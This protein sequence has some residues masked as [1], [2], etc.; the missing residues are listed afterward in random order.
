MKKQIKIVFMLTASILSVFCN[1]A[2]ACRIRFPPLIDIP[3]NMIVFTG[4]YIRPTTSPEY[5]RGVVVK[6]NETIHQNDGHL[7]EGKEYHVFS[8]GLDSECKENWG[9]REEFENGELLAI[10]GI[11]SN[12]KIFMDHATPTSRRSS[13][14][15]YHDFIG[16]Y[17][18]LSKLENSGDILEKKKHVEL[19]IARG[20]EQMRS[21]CQLIVD[22]YFGYEIFYDEL[23]K[24]CLDE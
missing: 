13:I 21:N 5:A 14:K 3:P 1:P 17:S 23:L 15:I 24:K 20:G 16:Y 7:L 8:V 6:V 9:I 12:G 22:T 18:F 2:I 19:E 4:E 10:A 11:L